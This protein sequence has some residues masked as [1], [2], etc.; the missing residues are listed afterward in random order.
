M[1]NQQK[2]YQQT[3]NWRRILQSLKVKA[4]QQRGIAILSVAIVVDYNGKALFWTE[5][6][7]IKL[8]PA[9]SDAASRLITS[10]ALQGR[11]SVDSIPSS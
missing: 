9:A 5:P 4:R 6:E 1:G 10:L 3:D 8:E 2:N 11:K 7:T